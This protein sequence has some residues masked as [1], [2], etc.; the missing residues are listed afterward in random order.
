MATW[1]T[2]MLRRPRST[3]ILQHENGEPLRLEPSE[4]DYISISRRRKT[5]KRLQTWTRR[6]G[7]DPE[8][9]RCVAADQLEVLSVEGEEVGADPPSTQREENVIQ[10]LLGFGSAPRFLAG[11]LGDQLTGLFPVAECRRDDPAGSL[12]GTDL[13]LDQADRPSIQGSGVELLDD[14]AREVGLK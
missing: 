7:E 3:I 11:D 10:H 9:E 5:N 14:H 8:G 13:A 1:K 4:S 12:Q 2:I 6:S